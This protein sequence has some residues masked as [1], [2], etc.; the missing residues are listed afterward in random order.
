[1]SIL[2]LV[3]GLLFA[4][5]WLSVSCRLLSGTTPKGIAEIG[6]P[7]QPDSRAGSGVR[8]CRHDRDRSDGSQAQPPLGL[9]FAAPLLTFSAAMGIAILSMFLAEHG[10]GIPTSVV[11]VVVISFVVLVSLYGTYAFL[12]EIED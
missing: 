4:F 5:Q 12:R 10:R 9:L 3:F 7:G 6:A 8:P 1:M 2:L 11:P